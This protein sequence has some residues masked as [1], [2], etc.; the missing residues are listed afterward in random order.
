MLKLKVEGMNCGHCVKS[1]TE[2]L[3]GVTGVKKVIEVSLERGEAVIEGTAD[4][5][6]L[7]AAVEESG[8]E[9]KV[10]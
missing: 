3:S 1:V 4:A 7:I 8:F 2:A 5:A 9:A 10:A 6:A